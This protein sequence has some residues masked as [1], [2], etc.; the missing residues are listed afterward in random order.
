MESMPIEFI[1]E[2]TGGRLARGVGGA[3][4][5]RI[6]TDTRGDCAGAFFAPLAGEK[7]DGHDFIVGAAAAGAVG[8]LSAKGVPLG[9]PDGFAVVLVDDT[10]AAYQA[11]ARAHRKRFGMPV[12]AITGSCGKT[13]T[14]NL[15]ANVL[16]P[17]R[18]VHTMKNENNEIGVPNTLLR[19]DGGTEAVVIEFGMR[20]PGEI[21]ALAGV[22]CPTH[23]LITNIE[24][25]HIGRL[26]SLEAI[27]DAKG[28]LLER[29]GSN[30]K[31]FLNAD[32][33]WTSRLASKTSAAITTFGIEAGDVRAENIVFDLEAARFTLRYGGGRI[34]VESPAP[35]RGAVYNAAAAAAVALSLG[36]SE[37]RIAEG[38]AKPAEESGR[39]RRVKT[40]DGKLILDDTYNSSPA[41]LRLALELLG[42]VK[43]AGRRVAALGDMLELGDHSR[44]EHFR[45]GRDVVAKCA[46]ALVAF[47]PEARHI[48]EGAAEGGWEG[49]RISHYENFDEIAADAKKLFRPGDLILVKGSRGMRM[50]RVVA[51]IEGLQ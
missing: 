27:A 1:V 24:P 44:G 36:L 21:A 35:G 15:L 13:T 32:N 40:A 29:L 7:F 41:A 5:G 6:I 38:I 20:G 34:E 8:C 25:T 10:L 45:I 43:W 46:D 22:A 48:A 19:I 42:N 47:G 12:V 2:A 49:G 28:E 37:T 50:E 11:I 30:E 31:A 26:G 3:A 39:M 4:A 17:M 33:P 51:L 18:I 9:L 16:A 14:K 23:G